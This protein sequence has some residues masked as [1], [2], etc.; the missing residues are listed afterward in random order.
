MSSR[1]RSAY[2]HEVVDR[3]TGEILTYATPVGGPSMAK[4]AMKDEC[5]INNIVSR[6]QRGEE[7]THVNEQAAVYADVSEVGDYREALENVRVV[8]GLFMQLSAEDRAMFNNDPAEYLDAVG[9]NAENPSVEGS[10][11]PAEPGSEISE[12]VS[13]IEDTQN[14]S[15]ASED[16]S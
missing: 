6:F 11:N 15:Q 10:P 2:D 5:D 9:R 13:T 8:E 12:G 3:E 7:I 16:A 1:F 4:Q 14:A